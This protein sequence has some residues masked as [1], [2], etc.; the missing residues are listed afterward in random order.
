MKNN[1]FEFKYPE[2]YMM[3]EKKALEYKINKPFPHIV[4]DDFLSPSAYKKILR[5]FPKRDSEI[6]K[7]PTNKHTIGKSVTKNGVLGLKEYLYNEDARRFFYE[8][9]SGLFLTFLEKLTGITGLISD[10]YFSEGGF[11]RTASGGKLDIHADFSHSDKLGLERRLN[12]IFYLNDDW[13]DSYGGRLGLYNKKLGRVV[14]IA[15]KGNRAAIFT[16]SESSFHGHPEPLTC[17]KNKFRKSIALYYYTAP[18]VS[19]KKSRI[20]FPID[21]NF[22][23][24]VTKY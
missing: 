8:F 9:N 23:P 24:T 12:L 19:R 5:A 3:A 11:H 1:P 4:I 21:P 7:T 2:L 17:P 16:T 13:Q 18:R 20:V 14:E 22:S 15:P 6:W 10:P